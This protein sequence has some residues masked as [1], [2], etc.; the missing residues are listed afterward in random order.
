MSWRRW[1]SRRGRSAKRSNASSSTGQ[2]GEKRSAKEELSCPHGGTEHGLRVTVLG[3]KCTLTRSPMCLYC[4]ETYLNRYST[5]CAS[6]GRPIFPGTA[7]GRAWI[8][9]PYLYTH[10]TLE[11][12]ET[13]AFYCG[14][15]EEG[16]LKTLHELN[17]EKYPEG[18][19]S[20]LDHAANTRGVVVENVD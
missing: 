7:V 18:T 9:T 5:L 14:R 10:L 13:A 16:W 4:T 17:P 19:A 11:C 2:K 3:V 12:C 6:C 1:F 8:N 20:V 15:W